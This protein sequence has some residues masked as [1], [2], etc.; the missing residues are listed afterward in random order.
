MSGDI[1]VR[2]CRQKEKNCVKRVINEIVEFTTRTTDTMFLIRWSLLISKLENIIFWLLICTF[3]VC[4]IIITDESNR[5]MIVTTHNVL[6]NA[7][8]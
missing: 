1:C 6:C 7:N 8:G 4:V 2:F 3:Y 5:G